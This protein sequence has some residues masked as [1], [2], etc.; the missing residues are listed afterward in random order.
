MEER[1]VLE[2]FVTALRQIVDEVCPEARAGRVQQLAKSPAL[3]RL[4][5]ATERRLLI[6]ERRSDRLPS[7]QG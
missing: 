7:H 6:E 1:A 2:H 3:L 4:A 5:A